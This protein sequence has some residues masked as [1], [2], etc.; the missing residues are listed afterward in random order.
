MILNETWH[1]SIYLHTIIK[2]VYI[3]LSINSYLSYVFDPIPLVEEIRIQEGSL[4][5]MSYTLGIPSGGTFGLATSTW[6]VQA[7]FSST[8]PSFQFKWVADLDA[9][10]NGHS[11]IKC[12]GLLQ[13]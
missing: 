11:W 9:F 3:A 4:F 13:W 12:S 2:E 10:T 8:I 6:G 5:V 7:P 1:N